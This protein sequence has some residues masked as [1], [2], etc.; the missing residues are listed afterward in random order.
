[1][2]C[3]ENPHTGKYKEISSDCNCDAGCA[4]TLLPVSKLEN[5]CLFFVSKTVV[6]MTIDVA[7]DPS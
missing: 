6:N 3:I 2:E 7:S 4:F 5:F 1:M